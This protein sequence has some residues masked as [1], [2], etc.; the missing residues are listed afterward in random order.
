MVLMSTQPPWHF[1]QKIHRIFSFNGS[2]QKKSTSSVRGCGF[3]LE[4]PNRPQRVCHTHSL[5]IHLACG[6]LAGF[7]PLSPQA[8]SGQGCPAKKI[9]TF[10]E[11]KATLC[12]PPHPPGDN[13]WGPPCHQLVARPL[14]FLPLTSL[15]ETP[16]AFQA[17]QRPPCRLSVTGRRKSFAPYSTLVFKHPDIHICVDFL[18]MVWMSTLA[19]W[20]FSQK[21][22][23]IFPSINHR[24]SVNTQPTHPPCLCLTGWLSAAKPAGHVWP[25]LTCKENRH[26]HWAKGHSLWPSPPPRG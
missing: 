7:R 6:W 3:F 26:F 14:G 16:L 5:L 20:H 15:T 13:A 2:F 19:P 1:S 9:G 24:Q 22:H 4:Q 21:I 11:Q 25:R 12:D 10:T 8:M 17:L 18:K 23:R